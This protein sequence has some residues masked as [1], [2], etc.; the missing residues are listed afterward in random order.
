MDPANQNNPNQNQATTSSIPAMQ[1]TPAPPPSNI[2]T[3]TN[4]TSPPPPTPTG[5]GP[6][7]NVPEPPSTGGKRRFGGGRAIATILGVILLIGGVGAGI[8]LVQQTQL[9]R[10]QADL[11]DACPALPE[12]NTVQDCVDSCLAGCPGSANPTEC[13]NG[14]IPTCENICVGGTNTQ[15]C[16]N[17]ECNAPGENET[18]CPQDCT[19]GGGSGG[20]GTSG[21]WTSSY[22]SSTLATC[23]NGSCSIVD[24]GPHN[25]I[26]TGPPNNWS[27]CSGTLFI[28]SFYCD[29]S[30]TTCRDNPTGGLNP[31]PA[32]NCGSGQ[33]DVGCTGG[34]VVAYSRYDTGID[35]SSVT[36]TPTPPP[37]ST[38]PPPPPTPTP[39]PGST[40]TPP[41]TGG[42]AECVAIK[43]YNRQWTD[44]TQRVVSGQVTLRERRRL[45]I[46]V[47]GNATYGQFLK[48]RFRINGDLEPDT[49]LKNPY[50]EF[51]IEYQIPDG[52]RR[53]RIV[54]HLFHDDLGQI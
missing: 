43:I 5:A 47:S 8:L 25:L 21:I 27:A 46:A 36:P 12:F 3:P 16:G 33:I 44:I 26:G 4:P 14:C 24:P 11:G 54:A 10:Q 39:P 31:L 53:L 41:P 52:V 34:G 1:D 38:P 6:T 23:N 30:T 15:T 20:G 50:G 42:V 51:Y 32:R 29:G 49:T 37:G 35:C 28:S 9:F 45:N 13:A 2:D 19:G 18:N 40:P 7:G 22:R 17:G 48:A